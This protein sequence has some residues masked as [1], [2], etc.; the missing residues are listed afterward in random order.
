MKSALEDLKEFHRV[1]QAAASDRPTIVDE[2]TYRLRRELIREEVQELLDAMRDDNLVEIADGLADACYVI[3]GT[4]VAYGIPL[5]KVWEEVH[6]SNMEKAA[7]CEACAGTGEFD[8]R[9]GG[10]STSGMVPC[11]DCDGLGVQVTYRPDGKVLKPKGWTPPRIREVI[12]LERRKNPH[13]FGEAMVKI[14]GCPLRRE[15][16]QI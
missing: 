14:E 16:D 4:A 2:A 7:H 5:D 3:I 13:R 9:I 12:G 10:I 15:G 11:P 6:R 8:E 1:F